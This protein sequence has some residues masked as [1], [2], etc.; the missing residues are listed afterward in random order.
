MPDPTFA[1]FSIVLTCYIEKSHH[2]ST[3]VGPGMALR[4]ILKVNC[5]VFPICEDQ[6]WP[7]RDALHLFLDSR[8]KNPASAPGGI[9]KHSCKWKYP[10]Y[11]SIVQMTRKKRK[12]SD[13]MLESNAWCFKD[14]E[15][16]DFQK[17]AIFSQSPPAPC[18]WWKSLNQL[19]ISLWY[20]TTTYEAV[21]RPHYDKTIPLGALAPFL[22]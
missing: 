18:V 17:S 2:S 21:S 15:K 1:C 16:I 7:I 11:P 12:A 22:A 10:L 9:K 4:N 14:A 13:F 20:L 6:I 5:R 19:Y 8:G 3:K